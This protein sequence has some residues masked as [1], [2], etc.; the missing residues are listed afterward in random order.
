MK[1]GDFDHMP[2]LQGLRIHRLRE[3]PP[4][5]T[6]TGLPNLQ[7]LVIEITPDGWQ[8]DKKPDSLTITPG[9]FTGLEGLERLDI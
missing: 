3:F 1:P 8:K 2:N 7:E 9:T 6:F 5:E 4:E